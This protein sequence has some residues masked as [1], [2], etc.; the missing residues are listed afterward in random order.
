MT[1]LAKRPSAAHLATCFALLSIMVMTMPARAEDTKVPVTFTGGHELAKNDYGRPI[2][3]MAAGLGVKPDEFRK[4]FSGVTPARGRGPTGEEQRR[5]KEAL[6]K[7][8]GPLKV[9]NERMDEVANYY[10]FRPQKGELWPTKPA[11]AYALVADGKIKEIVV[12][13]AGT[14]YNTPPTATIEGFKKLRLEAKVKY[15]KDL[16]K[17]GGIESVQIASDK[18]SSKEK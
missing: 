6:M 2:N 9:T 3:L 10:R 5:N 15:D 14:G 12:T 16:K 11:E 8:L 4:A 13:E 1:S 18:P 7:V 17:N